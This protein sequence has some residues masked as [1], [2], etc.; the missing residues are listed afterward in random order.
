MKGRSAGLA[1]IGA[2]LGLALGSPAAA[3]ED[4]E[5]GPPKTGGA[6]LSV[7]VTDVR[8]AEGEIAVTIYPDDPRRFLAKRGK[9][10]RQRVAAEAP[11]TSTCFWLPTAGVYA[12][13]VY[14]DANGDRDFDR[15]RVGL[16]LEGFGFSNDAPT[17]TGLPSFD[18]VRFRVK[19]GSNPLRIRLRYVR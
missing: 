2:V 11:T 3:Q 10:L 8:R 6:K 7:Q 17:K 19:A 1:A 16:P 4:C 15:N 13:A 18:S 14:H 9:L 5:G 12:V